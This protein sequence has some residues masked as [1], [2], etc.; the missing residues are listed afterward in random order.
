MEKRKR[1]GDGLCQCPGII[2]VLKDGT[3]FVCEGC[4]FGLFSGKDGGCKN[5]RFSHSH[6]EN[7]I[8]VSCNNF[9]KNKE[10]WPADALAE[11]QID[12]G[13]SLSKG[14]RGAQ[15]GWLDLGDED[16]LFRQTKFQID[17]R[18]ALNDSC[19]R[20]K[21]NPIDCYRCTHQLHLHKRCGP[22]SPDYEK[23]TADWCA[24]PP[25]ETPR[26]SLGGFEHDTGSQT[27]EFQKSV[28]FPKRSG[29]GK[30][31]RK[32]TKRKKTKRKKTKRKKTK[33]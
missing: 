30:R 29:G 23:M 31:K 25:L 13:D 33:K 6:W 26:G 9:F 12:R 3:P 18:S 16:A 21:T 28:I 27:P 17:C 4:Q 1:N 32:K 8:C 14:G 2:K 22:A 15:S 19:A 24:E 5:G 10:R 11:F 7:D 20:H